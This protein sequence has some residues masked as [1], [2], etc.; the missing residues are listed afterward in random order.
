MIAFSQLLE[1]GVAGLVD[2]I[3]SLE[4]EL[5]ET[6]HTVVSLQERIRILE[7]TGSQTSE[8]DLETLIDDR[9][10]S[11]LD[12]RLDEVIETALSGREIEVTLS[13]TVTL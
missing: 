10:D 6:R 9:I 8:A 7:E 13:G 4:N 3:T 12:M 5:R 1:A 2:A 11:A